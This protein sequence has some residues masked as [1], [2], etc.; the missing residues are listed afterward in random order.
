MGSWGDTV[1][2]IMGKAQHGFRRSEV[3]GIYL[4]VTDNLTDKGK[5]VATRLPDGDWLITKP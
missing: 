3:K 5:L 2:T 1:K 4:R